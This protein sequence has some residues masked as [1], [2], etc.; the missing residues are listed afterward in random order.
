[1]PVSARFAIEPLA[2]VHERADLACGHDRIDSY[3][4]ESVSQYVR[5]KYAT[6]C[7]IGREI[8]T[9]RVAS[10]YTLSSSNVPLLEVL[11]PLTKS[12][13][14]PTVPAGLVGC[15]G[16]TTTT[17][18]MELPSIFPRLKPHHRPLTWFA[19]TR[20]TSEGKKCRCE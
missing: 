14:Y 6:N 17:L 2:K 19:P 15:L 13:R 4:C 7:S 11:K 12:P 18:R 8:A 3:F 9:G 10:F 1:V 20:S 5:R 16:W